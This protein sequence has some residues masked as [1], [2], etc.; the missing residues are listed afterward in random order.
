MVERCFVS[1]KQDSNF[2]CVRL[3]PFFNCERHQNGKD[4]RTKYVNTHVQVLW[5]DPS[6]RGVSVPARVRMKSAHL[7]YKTAT[8]VVDFGSWHDRGRSGWLQGRSVISG[9]QA[10]L[11][12]LGPRQVIVLLEVKVLQLNTRHFATE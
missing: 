2:T 4:I 3:K 9:V 7:R 6:S 5:S 12:W 10:G 11:V 8:R 1:R